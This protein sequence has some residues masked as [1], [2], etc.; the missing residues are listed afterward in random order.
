MAL[1]YP[2]KSP[3]KFSSYQ[4]WLMLASPDLGYFL[5]LVG[6][7]E[8][9]ELVELCTRNCTASERFGRALSLLFSFRQPRTDASTLLRYSR[10]YWRRK[11]RTKGMKARVELPS[12]VKWPFLGA[13]QLKTRSVCLAFALH[14]P[15]EKP[16]TRTRFASPRACASQWSMR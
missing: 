3:E 5:P 13:S 2:R 8:R 6:M 14:R 15:W 7:H 4:I 1:I 11:L 10:T 9:K 12:V 16:P